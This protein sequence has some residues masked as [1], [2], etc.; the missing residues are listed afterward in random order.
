MMA[1]AK[2]CNGQAHS[3]LYQDYC[4]GCLGHKWGL[5]FVCPKCDSKC[6]IAK[7]RAKCKQHGT[8]GYSQNA[9]IDASGFIYDPNAEFSD[10]D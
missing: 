6:T 8:M 2:R 7:G 9:H 5:I 4:L 3:N 10:N 1:R